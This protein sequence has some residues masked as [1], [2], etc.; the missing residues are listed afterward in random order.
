METSSTRMSR[1]RTAPPH[2]IQRLAEDESAD[3][4]VVG[5][6]HRGPIGRVLAGSVGE[7][8]L[9]GAP[10]PVAIAPRGYARGDHPKVGLIGVGYDG[11]NESKLAFSEAVR[12]ARRADAELRII[13][14]GR[15]L[16]TLRPGPAGRC[17]QLPR[18][19]RGGAPRGSRRCRCARGVRRGRPGRR[20]RGPRTRARPA[21]PRIARLRPAASRSARHRLGQGDPHRPVPGA[22]RPARRREANPGK[23]RRSRG[24]QTPELR[25][26]EMKIVIGHDNSESRDVMRSRLAGISRASSARPR[27]WRGC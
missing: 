12:I 2:G 5:S 6:S 27:W 4:I 15:T 24:Q 21:R 9:T 17:G 7:T 25:S 14:V 19:G 8:L 13:S 11:F 10:C 22:G 16:T 26:G 23:R 3:L 1:S 18:E 20:A